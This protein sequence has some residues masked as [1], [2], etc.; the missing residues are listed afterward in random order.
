MRC[1]MNKVVKLISLLHRNTPRFAISRTIYE[2]RTLTS[3]PNSNHI[4]ST[5]DS[6]HSIQSNPFFHLLN[7]CKTLSSLQKIHALLIIDGQSDDP[8]LRTKLISLYGLFGRVKIARLMFDEIPDP[9]FDSHKLMIRWYFMNDL[10]DEIIGF[11]EFMRRTFI[12]L[13]NI[14]F[15]IVLKACSELRS[16]SEGMKL[17]GYILKVG[18]PDSFVLTGLVDMYAKCRDTETA[19]KVFDRILNRNVVCWT[20]MIVG[21]VQNGCAQEG[22]VLFN[23]MRDGLVEGN[24]YTFGSVVT[25]CAKLGALHQGKWVHGYVIKKGIELNSYLVTALVDMYVK[26]SAIRDA[27]LIFNE[28]SSI[29]LVSW[30]AMIVGYA[31]N[32][33]AEEALLLFTDKTWQ[34]VMPNSVTLASVLSACAQSP[35]LK[36]GASVHSQAIKLGL[37]DANVTNALVDMYAKHCR[38]GDANYLFENISDKDVIAWNSIICGY[39]QS[40]SAYEALKLY[41]RMRSDFIQP[42][43][44]TVVAVL[45]ACAFLGNIRFGS[46]LHAYSNKEGF[47]SDKNVYVGTA[48]LN[49]YAKCGDAESAR[50][51]FDRMV[52]KNTVT[53]SAMISGYGTQ[54]DAYNGLALFR[55]MLKENIEPTD[56]IFTNILS[57][58]SHTG[59]IKEGWRYFNTMCKV[60]NIVPS[61]RHYV[62]MVNLLSR[63]G[64]LEEAFVFIEKMP[65]QPD[66][67]VFGAFLHGCSIHSRFDLGDVAVQKMLEFRPHD[68]SHYVL[69]SNLY[70]SNRAW[71]QVSRVRDLMKRRGLKKSPA[72]SQADMSINFDLYSQMVPS[73]H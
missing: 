22:L 7:L 39:S 73:L 45:S 24:E 28:L 57:A 6:I 11:Y 67:T 61:M 44:V 40:G 69:M 23:R 70:A 38:T 13:D 68:A 1:K 32:G 18:R 71:S 20:S 66:V 5:L 3:V 9:D 8:F 42:D 64:W 41:Y 17:H 34:G 63:S 50:G 65:I 19:R 62:C 4:E 46:S 27:R 29:D 52:E 26:C 21:Y 54:G 51:I 58:C 53:W 15:S 55:D 35:N 2:S 47:L 72:T 56:V 43:C 30:T 31:Q 59:M 49:L 60:Y 48:L 33:Y 37:D 10:F 14:V 25:A 16:F 36:L 12:V